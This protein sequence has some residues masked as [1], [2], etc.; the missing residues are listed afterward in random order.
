MGVSP[1]IVGYG[2]PET[3]FRLLWRPVMH[4]GKATYPER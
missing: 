4:A 2:S 3:I 1:K